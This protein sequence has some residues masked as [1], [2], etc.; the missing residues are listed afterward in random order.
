MQRQH[1]F[2]TE[3]QNRS[4]IRAPGELCRR[5]GVRLGAVPAGQMCRQT[6]DGGPVEQGTQAHLIAEGRADEVDRLDAQQ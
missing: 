6:S 4:T 5:L 2:L 3:G 1:A